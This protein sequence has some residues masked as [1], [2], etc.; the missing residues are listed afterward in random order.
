MAIRGRG[1]ELAGADLHCTRPLG[2]DVL[3]NTTREVR[4]PG[5][6]ATSPPP[7]TPLFPFG[8]RK[9]WAVMADS[10]HTSWLLA[11][12]SP[13]FLRLLLLHFYGECGPAPGP[14]PPATGFTDTPHTATTLKHV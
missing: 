3:V 9:Q 14:R 6:P 5:R 8:R 13:L 7:S 10:S 11:V 2:S 4:P 1:A 12:T